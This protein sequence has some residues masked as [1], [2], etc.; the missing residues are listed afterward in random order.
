MKVA[1]VGNFEPE[2]STE[3]HVYRALAHNDHEV[4]QFQENNRD[5]W[6]QLTAS[7]GEF[8]MVLWTRTGWPPDVRASDET[9]H[10]MMA[11]ARAAGVPV[12]GYHLDRWWG[13]NRTH[14]VHSEPFF[15]ADLV[16][17]ADG[18]PS[19]Q[20]AFE[21]AGVNH[22]WMPPGVSLHECL[23]QPRLINEYAHDIIFVG[24]WMEY[25]KEWKYRLSLVHFLKKTYGDHGKKFGLYPRPGQHALRGQPLV[26]LYH[27]SKVVVGDSCLNGG[28]THYWSDRIPETLGR[29][30]FLI[31]PEVE[32]LREHFS[33]GEH[34]AT[35]ELGNWDQLRAVIEEYLLDDERRNRIANQGQA[36]V[37]QNHTYEVRMQQLVKLLTDRGMI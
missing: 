27:S 36:H 3:N 10:G 4:M 11:A 34:L 32:G 30:G 2:H 29:R 24:S 33:P 14:E 23:R 6:S 16:I 25:H 20:E 1:Y 12:V 35:Y 15:K 31:H 28:I 21:N 7:V 8:D 13:L 22:H 9:Q 19:H 37:L 26:D 5:R 17:T 18:D